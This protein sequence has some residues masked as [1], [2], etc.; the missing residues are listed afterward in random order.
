MTYSYGP[1]DPNQPGAPAIPANAVDPG[2]TTHQA[3]PVPGQPQAPVPQFAAQQFAVPPPAAPSFTAPPV[4]APPT[5]YL[6]VA[7]SA[8]PSIAPATG[9][10]A[11]PRRNVTLIL[12]IVAA[13]L[14]A[15]S[16]VTGGLYF[17]EHSRL[18]DTKS[19]LQEQRDV[20]AQRE[21][22]IAESEKQVADLTSELATT[23]TTLTA[24]TAERDVLVP[25]MRRVQ[26]LFDALDNKRPLTTI[27]SQTDE[28]CD[29][30]EDAVN[31]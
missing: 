22:K 15:V 1:E 12:A 23:K 14:L 31:R 5:A 26:E 4:S 9:V 13:V 2:V 28:A 29:K 11:A 17:N 25:C 16:G 10:A 3:V 18:S 7:T 30:A 8:P 20:V 6:P 19:T 27:L 24:T 21:A